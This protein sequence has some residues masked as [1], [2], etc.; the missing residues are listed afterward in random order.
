MNAKV[1]KT[2]ATYFGLQVE[3]VLKFDHSSL[4]CFHGREVVVDTADLIF[5][6]SFMCA[7]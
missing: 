5:G 1:N 7:A 2:L 4:I 3:V 6:C